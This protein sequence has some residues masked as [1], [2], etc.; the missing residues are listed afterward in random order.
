MPAPKPRSIELNPEYAAQDGVNHEWTG[1]LFVP[2]PGEYERSEAERIAQ[3]EMNPVGI[4]TPLVH[5]PFAT[6]WTTK[7]VKMSAKEMIRLGATK[8]R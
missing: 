7:R 6:S 2:A 1:T 5:A 4:A 8:T 3:V